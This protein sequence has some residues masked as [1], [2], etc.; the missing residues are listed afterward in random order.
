MTLILSGIVVAILVG[1]GA[2]W[3]FRQRDP[4]DIA[5]ARERMKRLRKKK[6]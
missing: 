4:R 3:L 6:P 1:L 2:H 5:A